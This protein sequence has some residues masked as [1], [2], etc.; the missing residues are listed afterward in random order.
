MCDS[1]RQATCNQ[2]GE[3]Q[4]C[5]RQSSGTHIYHLCPHTNHDNQ[6]E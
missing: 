3:E 1:H 4:S 2:I 5:N 6:D